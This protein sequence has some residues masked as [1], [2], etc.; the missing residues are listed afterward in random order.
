[1]KSNWM[2]YVVLCLSYC[3]G[4]VLRASSVVVFPY[5]SRVFGIDATV[6]G[7]ISSLFFYAY[8]F[9]QGIWGSVCGKTGPVKACAIGLFITVLG[10]AVFVFAGGGFLIGLSRFI[11]GLGAGVFFVGASLFTAVAFSEDRYPLLIGIILTM[12]NLGSTIAVAPLG[13]LLDTAGIKGT[14]AV[15]SLISLVMGTFLWLSKEKDPYFVK[16][17]DT[18]RENVS[19][20][21][22]YKDSIQTIKIMKG[23]KDIIVVTAAWASVSASLIAIQ[24]LWGV[25]WVES[26]TGAPVSAA[27]M[28]ITWLGLGLIAGALIGGAVSKAAKGS[29]MVLRGLGF[30]IIG[31]WILWGLL[32][33]F[34]G[35]IWVFDVIG[36]V[37]GFFNAIVIVYANTILKEMVH[38]RQ[39]AKI[40]GMSNMF[41]FAAVT[42]FQIVSGVVVGLFHEKEPGIYPAL[43]YTSAFALMMI[44]QFAAFY[45]VP[46][47]K[48][49]KHSE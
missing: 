34:G 2:L 4:A 32:S 46:P 11:S 21:A 19:I 14:F 39:T 40:I 43:A 26:A 10:S 6:I 3:F 1:M 8:G 7:L 45:M 16:A 44:A 25:V 47:N 49:L 20:S 17:K 48:T 30:F 5:A 12:G 33:L 23:N 41:C 9:T 35:A 27:R 29:S 18:P 28:C 38:P 13:F 15:L 36:F 42:V 37:L 31:V 22:V 24:A